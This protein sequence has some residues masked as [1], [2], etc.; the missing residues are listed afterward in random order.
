M[1]TILLNNI[2]YNVVGKSATHLLVSLPG[3]SKIYMVERPTPVVMVELLPDWVPGATAMRNGLEVG[4][5]TD[6]IH[7]LNV[8][9]VKIGLSW[10]CSSQLELRQW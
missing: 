7:T 1:G 3:C 10:I 6:V 4:V 8:P 5:V 9:M 2:N